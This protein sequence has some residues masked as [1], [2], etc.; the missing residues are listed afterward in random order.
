MN[1]KKTAEFPDFVRCLFWDCDARMLSWEKHSD[2]IISRILNEGRWDAVQ[3]LR[4]ILGDHKIKQ[5]LIKRNGPKLDRRKLRFWGLILNI[6]AEMVNEWLQSKNPRLWQE[7][8]SLHGEIRGVRVTFLEYRY[9]HLK[10]PLRLKQPGCDLASLDD[11]CCL[12]L[13]AI[14]QR[15]SRKDFIDIYALIKKHIT[16]DEMISLYQRKYK[17]TDI[18]HLLYALAYFTD[19]ENEPIP[20]LLR[21]IDWETVKKTI[22]KQVK[23]IAK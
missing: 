21:D 19:A 11:L 14:A 20:V 22:Q 7:R 10:K 5:W 13:S 9:P 12:K 17:T 1:R 4:S 2:F 6:D 16:L 18:G 8:V 3:W 15:G 23:S